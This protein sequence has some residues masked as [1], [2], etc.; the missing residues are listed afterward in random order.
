MTFSVRTI[1]T[2]LLCLAMST[3]AVAETS[4]LRKTGDVL[5][6]ALPLLAGACAVK[7]G[8][9]DDFLLGYVS[10]VAVVQGLKK[11]LGDARINQRPDGTGK[12]FPSGHTASA[13]YGSTS[14]SEKCFPDQSVLRALSYGAALL[15]GLSRLDANRHD[16]TQV[17]SGLAI[18]YFANG[19]TVNAGP[20]GFGVGYSMKF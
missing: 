19:I 6:Y 11:G 3:P 9:A 15:V 18:G 17:G 16:L 8:Q 4:A 10:H 14:L 1:S 2:V 20:G 12:G 5:Q 13:M 7:N